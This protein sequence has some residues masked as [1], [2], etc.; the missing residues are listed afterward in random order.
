MLINKYHGG[1]LIWL[2]IS[3]SLTSFS[4]A[5]AAPSNQI[6]K[7]EIK[8]YPDKTV[9][10][11]DLTTQS[12]YDRKLQPDGSLIITVPDCGTTTMMKKAEKDS[13]ISSVDLKSDGSKAIA[14]VILS[15]QARNYRGYATVT[16]PRIVFEINK[17]IEEQPKPAETTKEAVIPNKTQSQIPAGGKTEG[18]V[19]YG[20]IN[21]DPIVPMVASEPVGLVAAATTTKK[22]STSEKVESSDKRTTIDRIIIDPGHGGVYPGCEGITSGV[23]EKDVALKISL[24]LKKKLEERLGVKVH[25]TR[26]RDDTVCMRERI[27]MANRVKG[28][29]FISIHLNAASGKANGTEVFFLSEAR[30]DDERAIATLENADFEAEMEDM[31]KGS[32]LDFI[33]GSMTQN[34]YL[35]ASSE[36]AELVQTALVKKLGLKDRG[37]KQ[38]PFYVL[39]Y[40]YMPSILVEVGFMSNKDEEKLLLDPVFQDKAADAM[41]DAVAIYKSHYEKRMGITKEKSKTSDTTKGTDNTKGSKKKTK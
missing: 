33:L 3:L 9:L 30:S 12:G 31:P 28:D 23:S 4:C 25:I 36:L 21:L 27:S 41:A 5:G 2:I 1:F 11:L 20:E 19:T 18:N 29:L 22:G 24:K 7:V 39:M 17:K 14:T 8:E 15:S 40:T 6:Q 26:R 34:E 10:L 37:V 13:A 32:G 35:A 16:P 38:A